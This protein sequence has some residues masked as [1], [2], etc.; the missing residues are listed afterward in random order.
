MT[1]FFFHLDQDRLERG[2][3]DLVIFTKRRGIDA[4]NRRLFQKY[5]YTL[6]DDYTGVSSDRRT[7]ETPGDS[8]K[9]SA[10]FKT[11]DDFDLAKLH[12][13]EL[14]EWVKE[15]LI[16]F[17]VKYEPSKVRTGAVQG[18]YEWTERNG[19]KK[20]DIRVSVLLWCFSRAY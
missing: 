1:N 9:S 10:S 7:T 11:E 6:N 2:F 3:N 14:P 16:S 4:L 19:L 18:I 13:I 20:L 8:F 15:T 12:R 17:Y 5:G